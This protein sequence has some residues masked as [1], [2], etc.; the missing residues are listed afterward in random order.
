MLTGVYL[1]EKKD[2]TIYY[3][4]NITYRNKHI[5]LGS[6]DS[7]INA[8][9]AYTEADRLLSSSD[10]T[11]DNSFRKCR[12]LSYDKIV[13]L[14]NFRDNRMYMKTPIY[15]K[16]TY[17]IYFLSASC[18]LK[19]DIDDLFFYSSH[20]ILQRK[21]HL[22]I[23]DY[24]MQLSLLSRYGIRSHAV[25]GKDYLFAN[26]DHTDYRYSNIIVI[27]KYTGVS[28]IES[29]GQIR[30]RSQIH[31]NGNYTIG[32]YSSESKA[33]VAYNKAIDLALAAGIV[34]NF[35]PNY[36]MEYS[37]KEYADIY[38]RIKISK[39]Y[40]EYLNTAEV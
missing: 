1:A 9:T 26:G 21:G 19:F 11:I 30:Y 32:T 28:A 23:N 22:Y 39:K 27:N 16:S 10:Y 18:E 5:S 13:C 4:S 37:A 2:G 35:T 20:R 38:T 34:K 17:F 36:V 24:G 3:R 7:E 12:H 40:L 15:M 6:F 8:H 14:L 31:I 25:A 33:A 29:K